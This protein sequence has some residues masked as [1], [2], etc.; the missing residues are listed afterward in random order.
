MRTVRGLSIILLSLV[1]L[2]AACGDD[3]PT[4]ID[5]GAPSEPSTTTSTTTTTEP[6]E[7]EGDNGNGNDD[8]DEGGDEDGTLSCDDDPNPRINGTLATVEVTG[9]C[10]EVKVRGTA[11]TVTIESTGR[12]DVD[13]EAHQV[14]VGAVDEIKADGT[15]NT[16]SYE[17]SPDIEDDGC[18]GC[19][20]TESG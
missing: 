13:G 2:A 20:V 19:L 1:V 10:E 11:N 15:G 5:S 3:G 8:G 9:E 16:I 12:L 4:V 14:T 18:E 6:D 7:D 17:G